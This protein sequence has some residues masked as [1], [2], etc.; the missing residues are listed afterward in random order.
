MLNVKVSIIV[1]TY[2]KFDSLKENIASILNQD[3]FNYEVIIHDDG[4]D[5]FNFDAIEKLIP[6]QFKN[7]FVI[8]TSEKNQGTVKNFNCAI[9]LA[10]GSIIIPLSQDDVFAN[11]HIVKDVVDTFDRENCDACIGK[12]KGALTSAI[13]P[14][15]R[16]FELLHND[17]K[18]LKKRLQ[19]ENF[20]S[21]AAL[22]YRKKS[23][24]RLGLFDERYIFLEDYPAVMKMMQS[25][26]KIGTVNEVT[27]IYGENGISNVNQKL[28][29][30][31]QLIS[32]CILNYQLNIKPNLNVHLLIDR[33]IAYDQQFRSMS[34]NFKGKLMICFQHPIMTC[35]KFWL[36]RHRKKDKSWALNASEDFY[37]LLEIEKRRNKH[38]SN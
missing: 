29:V 20:I 3:Y 30:S 19:F 37:H 33:Y 9:R 25:N 35:L 8:K 1:L 10:S 5:N 21:G 17:D 36:R 31:K 16:D 4:S 26:M 28:G 24:Q 2:K 7:K 12:R 15:N 38:A 34:H 6:A 32:D 22:Y 11:N 18:L 13:Y 27:V 14:D 23:L